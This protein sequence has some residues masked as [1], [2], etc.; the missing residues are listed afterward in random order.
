MTTTPTRRR[1]RDPRRIAYAL[2][3]GALVVGTSACT[4]DTLEAENSATA[5]P[6]PDPT[7]PEDAGT[8]DSDGATTAAPVDL[9][10]GTN[11]V[12]IQTYGGEWVTTTVEGGVTTVAD[13]AEAGGVP[14]TWVIEPNGA[15]FQ[16]R[17]TATT[18]GQPSCLSLPGDD[19]VSVATCDPAAPDQQLDV[20][21]LDQPDQV[22]I[23]SAA[24]VVVAD[25]EGGLA[26]EPDPSSPASVFTL[27]DRGVAEG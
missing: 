21:T 5:A 22:N 12:D 1:A 20:A 14:T 11:Q 25:Q 7:T 4:G 27:V 24:G 3:A 15:T 2:A 26:L 18:D 16:V 19:V 23:S 6:A 17:T 13:P 9:L 10:A 8:D